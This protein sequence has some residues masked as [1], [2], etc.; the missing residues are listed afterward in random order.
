MS[1]SDGDLGSNHVDHIATKEINSSTVTPV[2]SKKFS[3]EAKKNTKSQVWH[4]IG[5]KQVDER[6]VEADKPVC[7]ECSV[8][9]CAKLGNTSNL[10]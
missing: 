4:H 3:L 10:Y 5:L 6:I 7:R 8:Q 2:S 9:V 1:D